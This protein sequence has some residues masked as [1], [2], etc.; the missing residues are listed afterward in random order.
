MTTFRVFMD[1]AGHVDIDA[2][3]PDLARKQA[4]ALYPGCRITKIKV[5]KEKADA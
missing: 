3:H 4:T 2:E 5:V 1:G